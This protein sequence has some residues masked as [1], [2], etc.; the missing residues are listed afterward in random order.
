VFLA[1]VADGFEAGADDAKIE[2]WEQWLPLLLMIL[3]LILGLG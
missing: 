3:R 1:R 2:D